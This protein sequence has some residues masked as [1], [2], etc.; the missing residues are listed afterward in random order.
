MTSLVMAL[1]VFSTGAVALVYQ[2]VFTRYLS[3]F[4]GSDH[5]AVGLT[6]GVFLAG[7]A[8]GAAFFGRLSL[9][10]RRHLAIY[11]VLE[12]AVGAWALAFPTLAA[13][14][15]NGVAGWS[16]DRPWKL[17]FE[18]LAVAVALV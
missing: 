15:G 17:L 16:F 12:A 9:L 5:I 10:V 6:L 13:W 11:A 1:A 4:V 14:I 8:L 18:G 3:R 2:V 7:L